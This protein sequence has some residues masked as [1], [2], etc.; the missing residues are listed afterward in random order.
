METIQWPAPTNKN[1]VPTA[2]SD[3][4]RSLRYSVGIPKSSSICLGRTV[5]INNVWLFPFFFDFRDFLAI[6]FIWV[7]HIA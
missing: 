5:E 3:D 2:L 4:I 1:F 6:L 7:I